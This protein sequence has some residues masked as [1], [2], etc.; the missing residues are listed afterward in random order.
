LRQ[1]D[2]GAQLTLAEFKMLVREQFFMLLLDR[3]AA[4][5]AIPKLLPE[6]MDERRRVFSSIKDVLSASAE[7]SGEVASRLNEVAALF[8]LGKADSSNIRSIGKAS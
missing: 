8:G 1:A 3:K 4:L 6:D 7:I 2:E 5:A